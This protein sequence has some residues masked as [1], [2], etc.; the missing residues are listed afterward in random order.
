MASISPVVRPLHLVRLARFRN[1]LRENVPERHDA[2]LTLRPFWYWR[3]LLQRVA[4]HQCGK[5]LAAFETGAALFV[6]GHDAFLEI[7]GHAAF[8]LQL[9]LQRQLG[10]Q[11]I[12][13]GAA[14]RGLDAGIGL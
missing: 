5:D 13:E 9:R 3:H 7:A 12:V 6:K 1:V 10:L 8:A 4:L 14:Q 2:V 11:V